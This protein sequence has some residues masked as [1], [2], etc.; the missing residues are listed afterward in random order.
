MVEEGVL[1]IE[2]TVG[3]DALLITLAWVGT[4]GDDDFESFFCHAVVFEQFYQQGK[5]LR[6]AA[7]PRLVGDNQDRAGE[8][9]L[10]PV[11]EKVEPLF[12]KR[13][14]YPGVRFPDL[15]YP[16]LFRERKR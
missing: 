4:V 3:A 13:R 15:Q 12:E 11:K 14:R 10:V 1:V 9:K 6:V 5:I 2:L 7:E 16:G 8:V